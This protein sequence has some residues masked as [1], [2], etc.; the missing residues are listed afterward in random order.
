MKLVFAVN[1]R[2]TKREEHLWDLSFTLIQ[3]TGL[4]AENR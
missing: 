1:V 2:E 4:E 3:T